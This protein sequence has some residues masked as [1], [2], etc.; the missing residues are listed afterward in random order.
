MSSSQTIARLSLFDVLVKIIPGFVFLTVLF[1]LLPSN[2][3]LFDNNV[4]KPLLLALS[5]P[6]SYVVGVLL[7]GISSNCFQRKKY[8]QEWMREA[9]EHVN[10][11][12]EDGDLI[13]SGG[14]HVKSIVLADAVARFDLDKKYLEPADSSYDSK[15]MKGNRVFCSLAIVPIYVAAAF[16]FVSNPKNNDRIYYGGENFI[17]KVLR[18]HA[19]ENSYTEF[20]RFQRIYVLH[21]NLTL[22]ACISFLLITL[23]ILSKITNLY[24]PILSVAGLIALLSVS[25]LSV[26]TFYNGMDAYQKVRDERLLY[27]YYTDKS[28][29]LLVSPKYAPDISS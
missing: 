16:G 28:G 10:I 9:R 6:I 27:R 25:F 13:V 29:S 21:R 19:S 14:D 26:V 5:I 17:F 7:Q 15:S 4:S 24:D 23:S 1:V 8:F 22:I 11:E 18:E 2:L 3:S 20:M 12:T